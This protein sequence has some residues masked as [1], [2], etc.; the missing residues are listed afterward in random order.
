[1]TI[2]T[3]AGVRDG[4]T[5]PLHVYKLPGSGEAA[6]IF[7]STFY[8][9]GVPDAAAAPSPGLAGEALT[10]YAGQLPFENPSA[11]AYLARF[12]GMMNNI[13]SSGVL[14]SALLLDRLWQNSGIDVTQTTAQT[15][16]SVTFPARDRA[17]A[18]D[19]DGVLV[20]LEVS[21]TMGN[22]AVATI[23]MS[24]TNSVGTSGRTATMAAFPATALQGTF[25]FFQLEAGDVGVRSIQSLTLGT[26]LTSGTVHLVAVRF[27][28]DVQQSYGGD[29]RRQDAIACG[30]PRLRANT[31]PFLVQLSSLTQ[32]GG[33]VTIGYAH[34]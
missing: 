1:M 32:V 15:V 13:A 30:F 18:T 8:M 9:A 33:A 28:S 12:D 10:A 27:L 22:G 11:N 16:D 24:Y 5:P 3:L 31:V 29:I 34:G 14:A 6:G 17:G 2:T 7:H 25:V 26:S 20:A 4:L 23:T 21:A 19:G